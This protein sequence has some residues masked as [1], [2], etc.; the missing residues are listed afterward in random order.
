MAGN[1]KSGSSGGSGPGIHNKRG[2]FV[3]SDDS[4]RAIR[5]REIQKKY[6]RGLARFLKFG[7]PKEKK[8]PPVINEPEPKPKQRTRTYLKAIPDKVLPNFWLVEVSCGNVIA[9]TTFQSTE[10]PTRHHSKVQSLVKNIR[11]HS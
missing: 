5:D 7:R 10:V 8:P 2:R 9:R 3:R 4:Q 11:N 6:R 1:S